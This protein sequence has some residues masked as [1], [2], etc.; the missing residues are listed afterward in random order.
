MNSRASIGSVGLIDG[1]GE[2]LQKAAAAAVAEARAKAE[3][4]SQFDPILARIQLEEAEK[5]HRILR[6][7]LPGGDTPVM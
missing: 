1:H 3:E 6:T 2:L 5:L 7:L 4:L